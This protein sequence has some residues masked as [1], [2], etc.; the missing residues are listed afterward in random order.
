MRKPVNTFQN[1][2]KTHLGIADILKKNQSN[3]SAIFLKIWTTSMKINRKK[4]SRFWAN[5][6]GFLMTLSVNFLC[7][8]NDQ[9]A[10]LSDSCHI[11]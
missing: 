7:S 11:Y 4:Y 6:R 9:Q 5:T 8:M 2:E 3:F 10:E 1:L